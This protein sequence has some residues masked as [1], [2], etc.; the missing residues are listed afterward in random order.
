MNFLRRI[1]EEKSFPSF[2]API[3]DF[4]DPSLCFGSSRINVYRAISLER[5]RV[6]VQDY[7]AKSR[8]RNRTMKKKISRAHT[9]L[10]VVRP[11]SDDGR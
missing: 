11:S 8:R 9:P 3:S 1:D 5:S 7:R 2:N 10:R 6:T 4:I